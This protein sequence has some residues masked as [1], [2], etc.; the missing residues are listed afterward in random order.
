M[1]SPLHILLMPSWYPVPS[2]EL[3]GVFNRELSAM[4]GTQHQVSVLHCSFNEAEKPSLQCN[5]LAPNV[6]EYIVFIPEKGGP[7]LRQW[8][9]FF[10]IFNTYRK[11]KSERGKPHVLHVLVAWKMGLPAKLLQWTQGIPLAVTEH[12]TGYLEKDNSLKGYKKWLSLYILKSAQAVTAVSQ[13][14]S[15]RLMELGVNRVE[16]IFNHIHPV[17]TELPFAYTTPK[18]GYRFAHVSNWEDRQKQT[19]QIIEAFQL[20]HRRFPE[21]TL[22]LI[23]PEAAWEAFKS[24]RSPQEL[25]GI[26]FQAPGLPRP[27]Y[28]ALLQEADMLVG[29][30]RFETFGL[31]Y[32]E[33]VC[34]G[35]PVIYTA[36]GGPEE[37]IQ[38]D[39]GLQVDSNDVDDLVRAMQ[40]AVTQKISRDP[41]IALKARAM[42]SSASLLQ[43]YTHV[44]S[45]LQ[46]K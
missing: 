14:L 30:S 28:A 8:R 17:F 46:S 6:K 15:N 16:T 11:I 7:L 40:M 12:F 43:K 3:N 13:S 42:F 44:Y 22:Q 18:Q 24:K 39:M 33:A 36:C 21:T 41:E 27:E 5:E 26:L 9:Y 19:T 32:A 35:M 31:T 4:L 29:F 45:Q 20:I 34:T 23:V 1:N 2:Q 37:F 38:T 25:E 10:H